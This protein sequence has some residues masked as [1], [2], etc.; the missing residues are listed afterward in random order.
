MKLLLA[1][2]ALILSSSARAELPC[3]LADED[4]ESLASSE[5]GLTEDQVQSLAPADQQRLCATRELLRKVD[6][7]AGRLEK[8]ERYSPSYLNPAEKSRVSAAIDAVIQRRLGG[9]GIKIA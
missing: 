4:Y 3:A 5:S 2:A 8:A 1:A 6:G 7:N 9:M